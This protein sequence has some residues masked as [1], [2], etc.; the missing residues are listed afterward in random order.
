MSDLKEI[1]QRIRQKKREKK[2]LASIYKDV[3][4]TSKH[5]QE[6]IDERKKL[7]AKIVQVKHTLQE[8]CAKE[9]EEI[10]RLSLDIKSDALVLSDMALN[11]FMKG[12][13]I[14]LT[15]E[16]DVKYEPIFRVSFKKLG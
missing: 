12:E 6:L 1:H 4:A 10:E 8:E 11:H 7:D 2:D 13:T 16:N 9:M 15:D 3:L 14:E 5:F